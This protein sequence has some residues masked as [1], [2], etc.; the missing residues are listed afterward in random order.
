M[1]VVDVLYFMQVG[2]VGRTDAGKSS[3]LSA[4]FRTAEPEGTLEIDGIQ[5]TDLGLHDPWS[6]LSIIPQVSNDIQYH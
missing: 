2:I 1:I 4:L 6:K 5:I 3:L